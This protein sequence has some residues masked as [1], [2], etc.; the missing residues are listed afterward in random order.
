MSSISRIISISSYIV[1][2]SYYTVNINSIN[3]VINISSI[4]YSI[5]IVVEELDS[6]RKAKDEE[7]GIVPVEARK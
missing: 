4:S 3:Y 1:D 5:S 2:I 6:D 7:A